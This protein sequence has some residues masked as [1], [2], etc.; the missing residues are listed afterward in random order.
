MPC[1]AL[2]L[3]RLQAAELEVNFLGESHLET[4]KNRLTCPELMRSLKKLPLL[5]THVISLTLAVVKFK[6]TA[7]S[8]CP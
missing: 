5:R 3:P 4:S 2:G 6:Y 1:R 8:E 7:V